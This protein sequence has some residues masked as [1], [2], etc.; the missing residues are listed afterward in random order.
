MGCGGSNEPP[1]HTHYCRCR[2]TLPLRRRAIN[3]TD[4]IVTG[5]GHSSRQFLPLFPFAIIHTYIHIR[6]IVGLSV[7]NH[8]QANDKNKQE[9]MITAL[10]NRVYNWSQ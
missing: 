10:V 3:L 6:L 2:I 4:A 8:L 7:A 5:V 1:F 9:E